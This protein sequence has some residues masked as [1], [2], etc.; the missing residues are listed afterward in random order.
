MRLGFVGLGHM[1]GHMAR[2]LLKKGKQ[3][4]VYD[5]DKAKIQ[6]LVQ[7]GAKAA[8][9]PAELG[10]RSDGTIFTMLPNSSHVESVFTGDDGIIQFVY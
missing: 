6:E 9:S 4:V 7:A 8:A 5:I 1:G 2:S 3:L 10:E